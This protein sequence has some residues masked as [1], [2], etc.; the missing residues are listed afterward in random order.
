MLINA[1]NQ[2]FEIEFETLQI[3][4]TGKC[5]LKCAHC[6][7][8]Y[9]PLNHIDL[10]L[11]DKFFQFTNAKNGVNITISG[12]EPFLHP[13]IVEIFQLIRTRNP[14]ELV[15]T[16]NG[17][18]LRDDVLKKIISLNFNKL[19]F[20]ISIDSSNCDTHNA[21][22]GNRRSFQKAFETINKLIQNNIFVGIRATLTQNTLSEMEEICQLA[23]ANG[24]KRLSFGTV[25]PSGKA[26]LNDNLLISASQKHQHLQKLINLKQQYKDVLEIT[27]EYPLK[28]ILPNSPWA[29]DNSSCSDNEYCINGCDAGIM[30]INMYSNGDITPC[31]LFQKTITH[32]NQELEVAIL[33]YQNSSII[34]NLLLKNFS[35][36]KTCNHLHNCGGGC[37]AYAD[38]FGDYLMKDPTCFKCLM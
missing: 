10:S 18:F 22:R 27:T 6:R 5:N 38:G 28:A 20:Q 16:T 1:D 3:E 34:K 36:C 21:F 8:S 13:K 35:S 15:I 26:I 23:I 11:I 33:E 17:Y 4:I 32:L 14:N 2:L 29:S 9:D 19:T 30:Q 12:G 37:R 25:V 31:A 24:V 7:A